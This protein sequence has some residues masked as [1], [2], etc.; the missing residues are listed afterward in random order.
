MF[1]ERGTNFKLLKTASSGMGKYIKHKIYGIDCN[2]IKYK[3][4]V[5]SLHDCIIMD[6]WIIIEK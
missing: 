5:M 6:L 3:F 4:N 1:G 2:T